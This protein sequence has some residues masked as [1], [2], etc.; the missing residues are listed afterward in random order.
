MRVTLFLAMLAACSS[1]PNGAAD[2]GPSWLSDAGVLVQGVGVTNQDCRMGVCQHNEN[3][4]LIAYQGALFL[5]H[6]TA[7]SQVLGSDSSL[8][9]YRSFDQGRSF[10]LQAR[11]PAP[12][13]RDH[14]R[15]GA[16]AP[17]HRWQEAHVAL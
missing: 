11:I 1:Q 12:S 15:G 4:D 5:V 14:V 13:D 10:V 3:T 2:A 16:Q 7:R 17:A 9:I 6:R 8:R